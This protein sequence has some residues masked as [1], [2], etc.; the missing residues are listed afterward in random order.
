M[1]ESNKKW[2]VLWKN[3]NRIGSI[4]LNESNWNHVKEEFNYSIIQKDVTG[5]IHL[6]MIGFKKTNKRNKAN[7]GK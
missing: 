3:G 1:N 6:E 7:H 4:E 5:T 2:I